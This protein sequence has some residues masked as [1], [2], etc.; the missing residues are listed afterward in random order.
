MGLFKSRNPKPT[1]THQSPVSTS[2]DEQ[3]PRQS[4]T[5]TQPQTYTTQQRNLSTSNL[6]TTSTLAD[7]QT[8]KAARPE[9]L[10][11]MTSYEAFLY[12][13]RLDAERSEARQKAQEHAW[14]M[15]AKRRAESNIWP[16]DPWRGGF[17]PPVSRGGPCGAGGQGVEGW[18]RQNGMKR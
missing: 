6:S 3:S 13:A 11:R 15:A 1:H 17:G 14:K 2:S 5:Q 7:E 4:S 12:H 8:S 10:T 18:L 9:P 16:S